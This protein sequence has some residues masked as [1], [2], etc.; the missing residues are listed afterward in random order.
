MPAKTAIKEKILKSLKLKLQKEEKRLEA[1]FKKL[2]EYQEYGTDEAANA[3]E[4]EEWEEAIALRKNFDKGLKEVKAALS[5][6]ADSK[7]G[8]C[9]VC[10][11]P[12]ALER[13]KAYP[14][15]VYCVAHEP[16]RRMSS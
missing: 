12:I 11:Q 10:R 16:K 13:L 8:N 3:Y 5:R 6:L 15:T 9:S 14:A 1:E 7:Y 4:M 2:E